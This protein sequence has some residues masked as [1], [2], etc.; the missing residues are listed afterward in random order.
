MTVNATY[1][2]GCFAPKA[3]GLVDWIVAVPSW[4]LDGG[5]DYV[6]STSFNRLGTSTDT[7]EFQNQPFLNDIHSDRHGGEAGPPIETQYLGHIVK[8]VIEL[9]TWNDATLDLLRD[10]AMGPGDGAGL[11]NPTYGIDYQWKIGRNMFINNPIRVI[12]NTERAEDVRNFWCCVNQEPIACG[13]GTKWAAWRIPFTAYRA[14]CNA[15]VGVAGRIED[16]TTTSNT[17]VPA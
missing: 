2:P 7:T 6:L 8:F 4:T 15:P 14:P 16:R 12:A 17:L 3:Y 11:S 9:T 10:R 5:G 13:M 1:A